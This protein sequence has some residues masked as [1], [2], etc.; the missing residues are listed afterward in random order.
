MTTKD[1]YIEQAK[2][3]LAQWNAEIQ[4]MRADVAAAQSQ[5][6]AEFTRQLEELKQRRDAAE[7]D[8]ARLS[9]ASGSAWD[10][11]KASFDTAQDA[12]AE[13]FEKARKQFA[14]S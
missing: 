4:K 7:A 8:L 5:G 11:M 3:Q 9:E 13:G 14:N 6:R 2:A 12:L 1:V 10:D